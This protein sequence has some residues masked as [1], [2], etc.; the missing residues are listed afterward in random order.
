MPSKRSAS[1]PGPSGPSGAPSP[2]LSAALV[3]LGVGH[4][5]YLLVDRGAI[6]W[7]PSQLMGP[8]STL[9]GSV[10]MVGPIVLWKKVG[11]SDASVGDLVWM[12]GGLFLWL[13]DLS[14]IA[15][16]RSGRMDWAVPAEPRVLGCFA[17]AVM[18]AGWTSGHARWA[19]TWSGITGS[20]LGGIWVSRMVLEL[21]GGGAAGASGMGISLPRPLWLP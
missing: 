13:L 5:L 14:A 16:G 21:M 18:V 15:E 12:A 7:P 1:K 19:W 20:I 3:C 6:G 17:V 2:L 9:A 4:G 11:G 8:A 10:A